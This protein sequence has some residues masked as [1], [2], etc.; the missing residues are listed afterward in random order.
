[1]LR[2]KVTYEVLRAKVTLVARGLLLSNMSKIRIVLPVGVA[3]KF[4]FHQLAFLPRN[5]FKIREVFVWLETVA[6]VL[7]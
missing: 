3:K 4:L 7:E 5:H 1:M 2:A 6:K